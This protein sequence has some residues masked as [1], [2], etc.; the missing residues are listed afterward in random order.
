ML[1]RSTAHCTTLP[2][3]HFLPMALRT[4]SPACLTVRTRA[5]R[6][7]L[8]ERRR[9]VVSG[10]V[11]TPGH[12]QGEGPVGYKFLPRQGRSRQWEG[13]EWS[14]A[15]RSSPDT[16]HLLPDKSLCARR[17]MGWH[18]R[19][20]KGA[21]LSL[22]VQCKA[23]SGTGVLRKVDDGVVVGGDGEGE[24]AGFEG[25]VEEGEGLAGDLNR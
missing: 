9:C 12:G 17:Y 1:L 2:A 14:E 25:A 10:D 13:P 22:K 23:P 7:L 16:T 19:E 11:S 5:M 24:G 21:F 18:L 20:Q 6:R 8:A 4:I 3:C 15:E